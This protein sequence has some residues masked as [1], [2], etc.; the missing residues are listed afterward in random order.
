LETGGGADSVRIDAGGTTLQGSFQPREYDARDAASDAL[1]ATLSSSGGVVRVT[2]PAPREVRRIRL[3]SSAVPGSG[4]RLEVYRLDGNT[5]A[6]TPTVSVTVSSQQTAA[7]PDQAFIDAR[8]ALRLQASDGTARSFTQSNV[9]DVAVRGYPTGPR[10]GLLDPSQ[11]SPQPTFFWQAPGEIGTAVPASEGTFDTGP[12]LAEALQRHIDSLTRPLPAVISLAVV[13]Q[14]DAPC[15]LDLTGFGVSYQLVRNMFPDGAPKQV[16]QFP[17]DR[18]VTREAALELP[19]NAQVVTAAI[20]AVESFQQDRPT[21]I[22][23]AGDGTGGEEEDGPVSDAALAATRLGVSVSADEQAAQAVQSDA[24]VAVT[25][26]LLGLMPLTEGA[27]VHAEL[28]ED[29]NGAP[30]GRALAEAS[31]S[32]GMAGQRVWVRLPFREPAVLSTL[33]H[34]L[35]VRAASGR[36][37]WLAEERAGQELRVLGRRGNADVWEQRSVLDGLAGLHTTLAAVVPT[38]ASSTGLGGDAGAGGGVVSP[39]PPMRL[40]IGGMTAPSTL[41]EE[42][43]RSFDIAAGLNAA[44]AAAGSVDGEAPVTVTLAFTSALPG[45][46]TVYPPRVEYDIG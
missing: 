2:L 9:L 40:Q 29:R 20:E 13:F 4:N 17:G 39:R 42:G 30:S 6:E 27:E 37:L 26:V 36:V 32:L 7:L 25:G 14:S 24:A 1:R 45:I 43:R 15:D 3:Q 46:A 18:A 16:L 44:L 34:W 33:P 8:F 23:G 12:A 11:P 35:T 10:T 28:R 21:P 19:R 22:V 5:P 31:A 41:E 38:A